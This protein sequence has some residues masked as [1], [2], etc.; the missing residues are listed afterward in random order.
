MLGWECMFVHDDLQVILSV[1]VDDFKL[2][3]KTENLKAAWK[4]MTDTG[5]E[6]DPPD[7]LGDYL[8][9]GQFPVNVTAQAASDRL[10]GCP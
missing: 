5:F 6:L 10:L 7:P 9:C 4:L 3:G 8:G 1:Y 2:V